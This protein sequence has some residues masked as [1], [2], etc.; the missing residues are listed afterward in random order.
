MDRIQGGEADRLRLPYRS[1]LAE[2]RFHDYLRT[3]QLNLE[4]PHGPASVAR[5]SRVP[6]LQDAILDHRTT[7]HATMSGM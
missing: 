4:N 6:R 7:G 3:H 2:Q 5:A 1:M